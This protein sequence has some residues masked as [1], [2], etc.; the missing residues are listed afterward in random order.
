MSVVDRIR[1][2]VDAA[3]LGE[4]FI[5]EL[6]WD[7]PSDP[8]PV[9]FIDDESGETFTAQP[10]AAKRG[11]VVFASDSLPHR[12]AMEKLDRA[13][14][15]RSI[16]RLLVFLSPQGQQWRWPEPRKSGGT[17]YVTHE[18]SP[19]SPN[20][21]LFQRLAAVRFR[22][23]EEEGL[24][25]LAVR[26]RVRAS[27]N[28]D[29]VTSR[30]YNE[31][32]ENQ[33]LLMA[34]IE[35]IPAE[36]EQAWYSSLLLNRLMFIYF[37]QRKEFLNEDLDY[38]RSSLHAVRQLKGEN[39]FYEYYR[40]FLVPL[41]H[42]GLGSEDKRY[43]DPEIATIIGDVPYINGGIF[44]LHVL[45]ELYDIRVPDET[46]E[47][48][49][50]FF[51]RYRWHLDERPT[52]NP[53]EINPEVLGYIFEKY[54]NQ[55]EQGAYYTREDVTGYMAG[56][57]VA[58]LFL[59]RLLS[60]AGGNPFDL[61]MSDPARYMP[62]GIR[63]GV[64]LELPDQ[65]ASAN[66]HD[67][68]ALDA[69]ADADWGL[70]GERW[71]EVLDRRDYYRDL[72]DLLTSGGVESTDH[73]VELNLDVLALA[74]DWITDLDTA[75]S[76]A[77]AYD[78]LCHIRILDPT[79]GSGAFLFAALD[80]LE[81]LYEAVVSKAEKVVANSED[82]P[83]V[84]P[85]RALCDELAS[86][87]SREY[88]ILK[89]IVLSNLY[90]VDLMEEATEIARLRLFLSL[91]ARLQRRVELEPLPD[92]DMNIRPGNALVGCTTPEDAA[93]R[94]Q[95]DL[96]VRER[97]DEIA[98][99]SRHAADLYRDF[100]ASQRSGERAIV[101]DDVKTRLRDVT[102]SLRDELDLLYS[103]QGTV[104]PPFDD[105]RASHNPFHWFVEFPEVMN[106]GGFD[107]VI[108]N[109]PY[110]AKS[111]IKS[112]R[113]SGFATDDVRDIF[114]PC[115]ERAASLVASDGRY[116]MIVPIAFQFSSDYDVARRIIG[117]LLPRRW[118]STYS[119][120]PAALFSAGLGVRSTIVLA[121]RGDTGVVSTTGL[122]RWWEAERPYL[123]DT[124]RY[125][126]IVLAN[127]SAPWPRTGHPEIVALYDALTR[128]RHSIAQAVRA[129]GH[130]VGFKQTALYYLS[131]FVDEPPAWTLDGRRAEQTKVGQLRFE[132]EAV[133][134]VAFTLLAG[135]LAVWWW[136]ATGDDFDVT[137]GLL[138][139][140]PI[141]PSDV[142]AAWPKLQRL[143][144]RLREEQPRHPVVTKYAGKEMGNY[145]MLRCRHITD[146]A[147]Q[148]VLGAL[149]LAHLWPTV[150]LADARLAKATGERPGTERE[151]PFPL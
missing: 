120:N 33:S 52:G 136:G 34:E 75:D 119:R 57:T 22:L 29:E 76:V 146:E 9:H 137:A 124:N 51:D 144:K 97:L 93:R 1:A 46:F 132:S 82:D 66:P 104:G 117:E 145:D 2:L 150:L 12:D 27:F 65:I 83:S 43:A 49:F 96:L 115:M 31:F 126:P 121:H 138:K 122:R 116:A 38:L 129:S 64:D 84:A 35:G 17:R 91:V 114:A 41:F 56:M 141:A 62:E 139:S 63:Y 53:Q 45:E 23:E 10:V 149:G 103:P 40:D 112:Y 32:R 86:H 134:D 8:R 19:G 113:Y 109:P 147:D 13:V 55:K 102:S 58:P 21:A 107:V 148:V 140:F 95:S 110:V 135:R 30:F 71:R 125:A 69:I 14:G 106:A 81:E 28:A 130:E 60:A 16:E 48:I 44:A 100:V 98:T 26:E 61:L 72:I 118:V 105:W 25:V 73:A 7:N 101:V 68:A 99:K 85:L 111:K 54:V 142:K 79:C 88:F 92:L 6:G 20:P 74:L 90:G 133:R 80:L 50:D 123:F 11:V 36:D 59:D 42:E 143:A 15:R 78:V 108:G 128:T 18:H 37:M 47:R 94:F 5:G 3:D 4:L 67:V 131:V 89:T 77:A 39:R 127:D 24:S 151:W 70:P 87:P